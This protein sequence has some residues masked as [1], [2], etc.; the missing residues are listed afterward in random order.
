ME[1]QRC[2]ADASANLKDIADQIF[3][4]LSLYVPFPIGR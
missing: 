4:D 2:A 3:S 1:R